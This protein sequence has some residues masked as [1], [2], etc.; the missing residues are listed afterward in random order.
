MEQFIKRVVSQDS[1]VLQLDKF[2]SN[3][4]V[5]ALERGNEPLSIPVN[6]TQSGND[7]NK[8][9]KIDY[10]AELENADN[11]KDKDS[12]K[13]DVFIAE[14]I[15]ELK[16][17]GNIEFQKK[18]YKAAKDIYS[19]ALK[20]VKSN[21][22]SSDEIKDLLVQCFGNRAMCNLKLD[23]LKECEV[24]CDKALELDPTYVK[25]WVRR[26]SAKKLAHKYQSSLQDYQ[27]AERLLAIKGVDG[28]KDRASVLKEIEQLNLKIAEI[29]SKKTKEKSEA[30]SIKLHSEPAKITPISE[31]KTPKKIE[32]VAEKTD[33]MKKL[34]VFEEPVSAPKSEETAVS[35]SDRVLLP[36][37]FNVH[38][39]F[40]FESAFQDAKKDH[41]Y[42]YELLNVINMHIFRK[43]NLEL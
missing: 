18:R 32:T 21:A 8:W 42:V 26:A 27:H 29:N 19:S 35:T 30:S 20:L 15:T 16:A 36:K 9:E 33:I 10:D 38:S 3:L 28:E 39:A 14:K 23:L 25:A 17:K 6:F 2:K 1:S 13:G 41:V 5:E 43:I 22:S 24:D 34:I 4:N 7:W 37:K 12:E 11:D 31:K 40:E